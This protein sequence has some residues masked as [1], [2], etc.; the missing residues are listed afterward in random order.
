ML[1]L[2][3]AFGLGCNRNSDEVQGP[4]GTL[5][6]KVTLAGAPVPAGVAV[7]LQHAPTGRLYMSLTDASGGYFIDKPTTKLPTGRYDVSIAP[8]MEVEDR[9]EKAAEDALEGTKGAAPPPPPPIKI[10][11]KY[12]NS[13][14]SGLGF[15]L[16]PGPNQ[17]DFNMK[18]N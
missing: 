15:E 3:A 14:E 17:Q 1:F 6:G 11:S 16:Q 5:S 8:P 12:L 2:A 10:P 13:H 18:A 7:A 9:S 4:T